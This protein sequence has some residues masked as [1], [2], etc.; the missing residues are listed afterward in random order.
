MPTRVRIAA[1]V[2]YEDITW[3]TSDL[4]EGEISIGTL[5]KVDGRDDVWKIVGIAFSGTPEP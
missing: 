3:V 2:K 4:L 5:M 1:C